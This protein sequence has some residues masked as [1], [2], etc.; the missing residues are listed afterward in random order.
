MYVQIN[1]H[2]ILFNFFGWG[3]SVHL[4]RRPLFGLFYQPWMSDDGRCGAVGGMR[5]GR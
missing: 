1:I 3:V 4:V 2:I 5:I